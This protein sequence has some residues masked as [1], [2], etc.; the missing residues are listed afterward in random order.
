MVRRAGRK[1]NTIKETLL[2]LYPNGF[3]TEEDKPGEPK[4]IFNDVLGQLLHITK[5]I[6]SGLDD[7]TID[8]HYEEYAMIKG[9]NKWFVVPQHKIHRINK[10][11]GGWDT[12][13]DKETDQ[14]FWEKDWHL[15]D[16]DNQ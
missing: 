1:S 7:G 5:D 9:K 3:L 14:R 16:P 4:D 8:H 6:A 12:A 13:Y 15:F 2:K 11:W 10:R